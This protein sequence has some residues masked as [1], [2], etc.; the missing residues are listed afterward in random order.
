MQQAFLD[1]CNATG[2][3]ADN[4]LTK[5]EKKLAGIILTAEEVGLFVFSKYYITSSVADRRLSGPPR[6]G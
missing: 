4:G 2:R 3:Q 5:D 6:P 1:E